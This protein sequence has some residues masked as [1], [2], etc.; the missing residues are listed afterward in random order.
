MEGMQVVTKAAAKAPA[1]PAQ[2]GAGPREAIAAIEKEAVLAG[3]METRAA[4]MAKV[5]AVL[6]ATALV[7]AK[8]ATT[9]ARAVAR[10]E[11]KR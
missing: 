9:M 5:L 10:A 1:K 7:T 8:S 3:R 4:T 11:V 6:A 2:L